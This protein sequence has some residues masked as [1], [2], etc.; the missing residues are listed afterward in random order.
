MFSSDFLTLPNDHSSIQGL[1]N[2]PEGTW[3]K[4]ELQDEQDQDW[5]Q[6]FALV[7]ISCVIFNQ[8]PYTLATLWQR[9][10]FSNHFLFS[11]QTEVSSG[12]GTDS[13]QWDVRGTCKAVLKFFVLPPG[14]LPHPQ[15]IMFF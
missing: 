7:R 14:I 4:A 2:I 5:F 15:I 10:C 13:G 8:C 1:E 11:G 9:L 12:P 3:K 6:I